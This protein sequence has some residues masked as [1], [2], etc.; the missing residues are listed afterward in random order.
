MDGRYSVLRY[1]GVLPRGRTLG[2]LADRIDEGM[3]M[4]TLE[5]RFLKK[6]S[7]EPNTGCWLWT[8]SSDTR[9]YG[10]ISTGKRTDAPL[11]AHRV[12]YALHCGPIPKGMNVCHTCDTPACVNPDHLWIGSHADNA[13]DMVV[14]GRCRPWTPEN[15]YRGRGY[16]SCRACHAARQRLWKR[17]HV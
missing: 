16:R 2:V 9:G 5:E 15:T 10:H 1:G 12:S 14:K 3:E 6:I 17:R 13:R 4:M 8:G 11:M 7:P